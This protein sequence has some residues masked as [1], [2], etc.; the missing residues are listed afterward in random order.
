MGFLNLSKITPFI[1][2]KQSHLIRNFGQTVFCMSYNLKWLYL[3]LL[4]FM[5][6]EE[7][8]NSLRVM[9]LSVSPDGI[10]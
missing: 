8:I 7:V 1:M 3:F 6:K 5:P 9:R 10:D 4:N 2:H